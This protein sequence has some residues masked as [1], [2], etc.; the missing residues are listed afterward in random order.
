MGSNRNWLLSAQPV[1]IGRQS[2]RPCAKARKRRSDLHLLAATQGQ[3]DDGG[4]ALDLGQSPGDILVLSAADTELAGLAGVVARSNGTGEGQGPTVRLANY[5]KL[6]HPMSVDVYA[7]RMIPQAKLVIVRLLG[8]EAYWQYGVEQFAACCADADV[9]VAFLP[10]DDQPDESLARRSTV[11]ADAWHRLWRYLA[12]GGPENLAAFVVYAGCLTGE[13]VTDPPEPRP[14]LRAGI[15]G[16]ESLDDWR[17][18]QPDGP[19]AAIVFYRALYQSGTLAP[20]D[21]LVRALRERGIAALPLYVASLKDTVSAD[22]VRS[23]TEQAGAGIVLNC[24]G[25]AVSAPGAARAETP[26]D[27][28]WT[29]PSCKWCW[30][31]GQ[32]PPGVRA[33]TAFRP[34]TSPCKWPCRRWTAAF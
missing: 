3:I 12:E 31:A 15:Y 19:A 28:T 8:G 25:F 26:F 13:A 4:E 17:R 10:G 34:A 33:L 22:T 16:H 9:P 24:T 32:R 29:A 20:V 27:H 6:S 1:P 30:R 7:E 18:A 2:K 11:G 23:L 14:V 5:L 21:A